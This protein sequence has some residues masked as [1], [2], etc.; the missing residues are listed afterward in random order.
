[1]IQTGRFLWQGLVPKITNSVFWDWPRAGICSPATVEGNRAYLV[2]NRGE[3]MC[4]DARGLANGNDGPFLEEG[5]HMTRQPAGSGTPPAPNLTRL[6]RPGEWLLEGTLHPDEVFDV[7]TYLEQ[8]GA[9]D[10]GVAF[11]REIGHHV[12]AEAAAVIS[13]EPGALQLRFLQTLTEIATEKNSTIIF[14]LPIDI[15]QSLMGPKKPS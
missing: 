7:L 8:R 5:A 13:A 6:E 4:L 15:M 12:A 3:V 1:M 2:S 9:L 11:D 14:P 10:Q